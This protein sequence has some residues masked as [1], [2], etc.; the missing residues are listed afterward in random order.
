MLV[1]PLCLPKA[2]LCLSFH[3]PQ[4]LAAKPRNVGAQL[5]GNDRRWPGSL[6]TLQ[7]MPTGLV[8][9]KASGKAAGRARDFAVNRNNSNLMPAPHISPPS[10]WASRRSHDAVATTCPPH[11]T[12]PAPPRALRHGLVPSG[13]GPAGP[14]TP[15]SNKKKKRSQRRPSLP[16]RIS[17]VSARWCVGIWHW[18]HCVPSLREGFQ[19]PAA[20]REGQ[21]DGGC[22]PNGC[23]NAN[24]KTRRSSR[25]SSSSS[26]GHSSRGGR[27]W[28]QTL[29]QATSRDAS[30][31]PCQGPWKTELQVLFLPKF[32]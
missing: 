23:N 27:G 13:P 7:A 30:W 29:P 16:L 4:P 32:G 18:V 2:V 31:M 9:W 6:Q 21:G 3:L 26:G 25:S 19:L 10:P 1:G 20:M 5:S 24:A 17:R 12:S 14:A 28:P 15:R 8:E 22:L 11:A